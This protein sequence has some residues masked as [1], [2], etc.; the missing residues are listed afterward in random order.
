M[1]KSK[2][3]VL[4]KKISSKLAYSIGELLKDNKFSPRIEFPYHPGINLMEVIWNMSERT[5]WESNRS[6]I[7][8]FEVKITFD[9]FSTIIKNDWASACQKNS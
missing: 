7:S 8:L 6:S 5:V 3:I 1:T 2:P 9:A 4:V